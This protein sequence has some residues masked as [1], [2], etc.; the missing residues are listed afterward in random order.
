MKLS[1]VYAR[2]YKSFNFDQLRKSHDAAKHGDWDKYDGKIFPY[3]R[4]DI[5]KDITTVVGANESGKSHLLS[6]ITKAITGKG[7]S[8][9]D[10]CR[11]CPY[12]SVERGASCWPHLGV[13]WS[14]VSVAE[15]SALG[16]EL[17]EGVP[18]AFSE[19][20]M[21]RQDPDHLSVYIPNGGEDL[22]SS[23]ISGDEARAFGQLLP[24]PFEI[25]AEIAL[26]NSISLA[27]LAKQT[28]TNGAWSSRSARMGALDA[29]ERMKPYY[30]PDETAFLSSAP[31]LLSPMASL[32]GESGVVTKGNKKIDANRRH[33]LATCLSSWPM[34]N[35]IA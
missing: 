26:P 14:N 8:R 9:R 2:F 22:W 32:F 30:T 29:I 28:D 6:A 3:I 12:F 11:Y 18:E 17:G 7:I 21:F 31:K 13:G 10:L 15:A 5:E 19:F 27:W 16:A 25:N 1:T 33:L 23:T 34:W 35:P 20:L 24:Q 4:I